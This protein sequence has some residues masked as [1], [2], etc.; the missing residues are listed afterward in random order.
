MKNILNIVRKAALKKAA[1]KK[2][3]RVAV[4]TANQQYGPQ[5]IN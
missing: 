3:R 1:Q 5:Q 4:Q 2:A